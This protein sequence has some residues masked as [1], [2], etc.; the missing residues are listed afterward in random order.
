[1]PSY[2]PAIATKMSKAH[3]GEK[4]SLFNKWCKENWTC[5]RMKLYLYLQPCIE[6][7]SKWIKYL[8]VRPPPKISNCKASKFQTVRG[9]K[10]KKT[11]QD[12]GTEKDFLNKTL[13]IQEIIPTGDK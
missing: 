13:V 8:H 7:K 9:K 4:D 1:M 12:A 11:Y 5:R 6:H 10:M 2:K 3:I